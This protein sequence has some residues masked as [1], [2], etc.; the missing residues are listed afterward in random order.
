MATLTK[1]QQLA[2][3]HLHGDV[4]IAA[5]AGSGKTKVLTERVIKLLLIDK[6]P[7]QSLLM[8]T[9][10]NAAAAEM[11]AR[12]RKELLKAKEFNLASQIDAAFIMTF[13]AYALYLV[14]KYG[15]YL[16]LSTDIGVYEETLYTIER[17]VT[18][19]QLFEEEYQQK[20]P[21]FL[22]FIKQFVIN[23]DETMKAFNP[24]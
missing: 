4:L 9:F 3:D 1:S 18:L 19:N 24:R 13:D 12:I 20:R 16:G 5:G 10:T 7:L 21:E 15:H 6:V 8:L 11:K 14:K 17:K 2:R 23:Q 22:S